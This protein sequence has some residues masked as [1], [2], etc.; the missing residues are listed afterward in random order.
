[1]TGRYASNTTVSAEKSKTEIER[2]LAKYGADAFFYQVEGAHAQVGFRFQNFR[3]R[4]DLDMPDRSEFERTPTGQ[5]R[6]EENIQSAWEKAC[7]QRWRALAGYI[8]MTLE[9]VETGIIDLQTALMPHII[10]PD[11]TTLG[12]WVLPAVEQS[13]LTGTMPKMLPSG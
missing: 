12:Q 5:I 11:N 7:R 10:M 3:F 13:Y 4:L 6:Y 1:M 2:T 9:A 8:K